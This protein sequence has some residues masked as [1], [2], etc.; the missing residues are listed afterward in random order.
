MKL[1]VA[2][3]LG[4]FWDDRT[5]R[6]NWPDAL[7]RVRSPYAVHVSI[8]FQLWPPDFN[9]W[10]SAPTVNAWSDATNP[11][12]TRWSHNGPDALVKPEQCN[13]T[14]QIIRAQVQ[15]QAPKRSNFQ[16]WAHIIPVINRN[17]E[18]FQ[19]NLL[20]TKIA[21]FNIHIIRYIS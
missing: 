1:A 13:R 8:Q 15:K 20:T 3:L 19:T 14:D 2:T 16:T 17:H 11:D 5:L 10:L 12:R 6:S 18:G 7:P 4:D 21:S 9:G